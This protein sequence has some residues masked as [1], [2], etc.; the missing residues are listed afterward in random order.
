MNNTENID[1]SPNHNLQYL[2]LPSENQTLLDLKTGFSYGNITNRV[3]LYN[4]MIFDP[5]SGGG[6]TG[7]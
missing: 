2:L 5:T 6:G 1:G 4:G 7:K 3:V